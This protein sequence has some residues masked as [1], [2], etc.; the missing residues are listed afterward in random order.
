MKS[1]HTKGIKVW[2]LPTRIWHFL[3]AGLFLFLLVSG[4][5]GG[6]LMR[7]H[8]LSGCL[9]S[10]LILFRLVW[11]F[12]GSHHARFKHFVRSPKVVLNYARD[13]VQGNA[14]HYLGHN[15]LGAI[16]VVLIIIGFGLQALSGLVTSDDVLWNGPLYSWANEDIADWGRT[17]HH[18]L[19]IVLKVLV[20]VHILAVFVHQY[21]FKDPIIGAMVHGYKPL[22]NAHKAQVNQH[23]IALAAALLITGIWVAWLWSLPL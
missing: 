10:G 2:D 20:I 17:I 15:P 22:S 21:Y 5:L 11:G 9:L 4:E 7:Y 3:V 1:D 23:N 16:M 8:I 6:Q 12:F 18:T 19:E 13:L 14:I